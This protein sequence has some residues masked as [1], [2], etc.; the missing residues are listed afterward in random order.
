MNCVYRAHN[1]HY[2]PGEA[3]SGGDDSSSRAYLPADGASGMFPGG[4]T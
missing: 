3:Y 2:W 4:A 1:D